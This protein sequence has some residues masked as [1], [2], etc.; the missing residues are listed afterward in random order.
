MSLISRR[1]YSKEWYSYAL[2]DLD[3]QEL[4][5][6]NGSAVYHGDDEGW[7]EK[8]SLCTRRLT[9]DMGS[10]SP[11]LIELVFREMED[12]L[13]DDKG[14]KEEMEKAKAG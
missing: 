10:T 11:W 7:R 4:L 13:M 6:E 8:Y 9:G 3:L 14:W 1:R 2:F 5:M 12:L